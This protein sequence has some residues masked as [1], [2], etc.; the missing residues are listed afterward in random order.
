MIVVASLFNS[1]STIFHSYDTANS[2]ETLR[3]K[4]GA[5]LFIVMF[6]ALYAI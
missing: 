4:V 2:E 5:T 6:L 3:Y 1:F